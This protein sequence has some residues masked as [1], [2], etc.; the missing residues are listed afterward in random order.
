MLEKQQVRQRCATNAIASFAHSIYS[1]QY[2]VLHTA[3]WTDVIWAPPKATKT[4]EQSESQATRCYCVQKRE[5]C[6]KPRAWTQGSRW[7][8]KHGSTRV[9]QSRMAWTKHFY[10]IWR[11]GQYAESKRKICSHLFVRRRRTA[12]RHIRAG[13]IWFPYWAPW[14][15][16]RGDWSPESQVNK[17]IGVLCSYLKLKSAHR[18]KV[19]LTAQIGR[20]VDQSSVT[21]VAVPTRNVE[22]VT[23][24]HLTG[25]LVAIHHNHLAQVP[26][27]T[28]QVFNV[29]AVCVTCS[30]AEQ[31]INNV[32]VGIQ[33]V[34]NWPC[35]LFIKP[36]EK[37]QFKVYR[38]T[39][40]IQSKILHPIT[41]IFKNVHF[42]CKRPEEGHQY[43]QLQIWNIVL[44]RIFLIRISIIVTQHA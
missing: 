42:D 19:R 36:A 4:C 10:E 2:A 20:Q 33:R 29:M 8:C 43:S 34:Q 15:T 14:C 28:R 25:T 22:G 39:G 7:F 23:W 13:H 37:Q 3:C 31:A 11:Q 30:V 9:A 27:Q 1:I 12:S 21:V 38:Q 6:P 24:L 40:T 16:N 18:T 35:S 17:I 41:I 44:P 5:D 32:S 26:V